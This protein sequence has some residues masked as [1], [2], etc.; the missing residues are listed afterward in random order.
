MPDFNCWKR[1]LLIV[2]TV[3]LILRVGAAAVLQFQLDKQPGRQFL[4]AGD[5]TGYWTLGEQLA[6]GKSFELYVPPRRI[7]RT[8]GFPWV[9]SLGMR[10]FGD[11]IIYIRLM[12]ALVG[13][14]ACGLVFWLGKELVDPETGVIAAGVAAISPAFVGFTPLILSETLFAATM[15]LSL[16]AVAKL[17]N[18]NQQNQ[19]ASR[20]RYLWAFLAGVLVGIA[21]LVRPSW[22][23]VGPGCAFLYWALAQRNRHGFCLAAML[24]LGLAVSL[25]PWTIRNY[26]LTGHIVP[27]TLWVG[28]S[29]YD[30]M[31]PQ[32]TGDSDMAFVER[33][34]VYQR[35]SEFDADR[36]YRDAAWKYAAAHPA[37]IVQLAGIKLAR[38]WSPWP[39]AAQFRTWYLMIPLALFFAAIMLAAIRGGWLSRDR[40]WL[41][42]L[43]AGPIVYFAGIHALFIG[44]IRYRLP[45]EYPLLV[46]TAIGIRSLLPI[47]TKTS[48]HDTQDSAEP[49]PGESLSLS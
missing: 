12:L 44:S 33:D 14:A 27:T 39:N 35:M 16:I 15:L 5:A 49:R 30:G 43:T 6:N 29:L 21:T 9:L 25:A 26:R 8:P 45:A 23:L 10:M 20:Q 13:T 24:C 11:D 32:A 38:Y 28:P 17:L 42:L 47:F 41:C 1:W 31:N 37:R 18:L 34:G 2:M 48:P 19:Q 3:A 4:I 7:M 46:L 22:L 36:Y 40:F